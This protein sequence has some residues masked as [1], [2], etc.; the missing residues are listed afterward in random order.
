[1]VE[2]LSS[3]HLALSLR[4]TVVSGLPLLCG[5]PHFL[6]TSYHVVDE[7]T[8]DWNSALLMDFILDIPIFAQGGPG[9]SSHT[10]QLSLL[11]I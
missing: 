11:R 8:I 9:T 10:R 7:S 2:I 1:M 6:E 5:Y 3:M 4:L